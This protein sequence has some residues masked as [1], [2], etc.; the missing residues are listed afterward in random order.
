MLKRKIMD[1]LVKWKNEKDKECLLVTGARQV[2]KTFIIREFAKQNYENVIELNFAAVPLYKKIFEDDL[3]MDAIIAKLTKLIPDARFKEGKTIL[4][5]DEIQECG[6]ARTALKFIAEDNRYDCIASGSMLGIAYKT[7]RSIP[8][9][10]EYQIEMF[11]LDFEEFLWAAG[12]DDTAIGRMREYL[13]KKE[14]VP[15]LINDVMIE[16][17]REYAVIGGMP[18]VVNRYLETKNYG[19]VHKEQEKIIAG[20]L[21]DIAKYAPAADK[22]KARNC[23]LSIPSQLEKENKKFQYSAVEKNSDARKFESSLEWLRDAGLIKFCYNVSSPTFPLPA[24]NQT[25]YFK[26]YLTDV[27]ILNA[28]YGFGMKAAVLDNTLTGPAKGGIYESLIADILLKKGVPLNY[29]KPNEGRQ[30]IEFLLT[31]D[32]DII[33]LEVKSG[34]GKTISLDEFIRRFDPPYALKLISGNIG[35]NGKKLTLPL[36]MAM[37]L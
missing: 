19:L 26:V 27:G 33:P 32:L 37:F 20:Y 21:N 35:E 24:Y 34:N 3:R 1:V 23:Y 13:E 5:L 16:K 36:Y 7:T 22:P 6:D 14:Q 31:K 15:K 4:F 28:M 10:Y 11:A 18:S 30:E 9:G 17:L 8:V 25:G 12:Y 2:G 29:Y